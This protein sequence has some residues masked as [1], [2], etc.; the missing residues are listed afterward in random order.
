MRRFVGGLAFKISVVIALVEALALAAVGDIYLL[1]FARERRAEF[2]QRMAVPAILMSE[3]ALSYEAAA[4]L[5]AMTS[6]IGVPVSRSMWVGRNRLVLYSGDRAE[7]GQAVDNLRNVKAVEGFKSFEPVLVEEQ[8]QVVYVAPVFRGPDIVGYLY[9][10]VPTVEVMSQARGMGIADLVALA[11]IVVV[12]VGVNVFLLKVMLLNRLEELAAVLRRVERGDLEVEIKGP[13]AGDE[14]GALQRGV[15]AMVAQLWEMVRSLE[16][17][18]A[19]RTRDLERRSSQLQAVAEVGSAIASVRDFDVLLARIT[20]LISE[21]F[22]YYHVGIFLLDAEGEYVVLR[23]AN[24]P[25]GQRMLAREHRLAVGGHSIVGTVAATMTP[26]IVLDVGEDAEYFSN[27]DLPETRSEMALPLMVG[28]RLLGVLDIQSTEEAAFAEEDV[29]VL[30]VLAE[31]VAVAIDNVRLL[32][33]VQEAAEL[34]RRAYGELSRA[35]WEELAQL[36]VLGYRSEATRELVPVVDRWEPEMERAR[37]EGQVVVIDEHTVA[38]PVKAVGGNVVGVLKF[39]KPETGGAWT[40]RQIALLES[41][42][43]RLGQALESARFYRETQLAAARELLLREVSERIRAAVT[44]EGV[45]Q[46]AAREIGRAWQRPAFVY[47][48]TI[49]GGEGGWGYLCEGEEVRRI[50]DPPAWGDEGYVAPLHVLEETVH[51]QIGVYVEAERPLVREEQVLMA[52]LAPRVAAALDRARLYEETQRR[53][54]REQMTRE[55]TDRMRRTVDWD[56]LMQ[57]ALREM[58][59]AL[60]AS[61]AFVQWVPQ[62]IAGEEHHD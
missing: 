49:V 21:R 47:V 8:G 18:V 27:P 28:G 26:R 61:R 1:R 4:D 42:S 58:S 37:R 19:E 25:G 11:A 20:H 43:D 44:V 35:A 6:L 9:L 15:N 16:Q 60:H 62:Q 50:T 30:R 24:S 54:A 41:L 55:I 13:F 34:Q 53:A 33:E 56:E 7:V 39:R 38:V 31:Q 46:A 57:V 10:E 40:P 14:V 51:G 23:A 12:T 17:R 45:A 29:E 59:G 3:G 52:S 32:A 22:G 48:E 5:E 2:E 36:Q